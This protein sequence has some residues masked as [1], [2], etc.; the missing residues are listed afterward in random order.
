MPY[1][2]GLI[3]RHAKRLGV[4]DATLKRMRA[5]FDNARAEGDAIRRKIQVEQATL[6]G[7]VDADVPDEAAVMAQAEKIG[8][9]SVDQRKAQLRAIIAVRAM[10]TPEQRAE[11]TKI[12]TEKK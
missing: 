5:T 10:L 8:A 12:R 2:G 11:L 6:R 7:L 4:S 3:E 1:P 9:M